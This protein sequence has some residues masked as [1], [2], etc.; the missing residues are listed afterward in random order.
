MVAAAG[1]GRGGGHAPLRGAPTDETWRGAGGTCT[2]FGCGQMGVNTVGVA[3][4]VIDFVIFGKKVRPGTFG[5][6]KVG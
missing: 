3:A 5:K 2:Q 4:K 6:I 1:G